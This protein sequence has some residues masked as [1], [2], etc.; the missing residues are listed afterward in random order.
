MARS[1]TSLLPTAGL[2]QSPFGIL[3]PATTTYSHDEDY[4]T[5]GFTYEV[6]DAGVKIANGI[7]YGANQTPAI[8]VIDN[9]DSTE[10]FKTYYPFDIQASI[11]LSTFGTTPDEVKAS[12]T[13][14]L[15]LVTQ[16]AIEIEFWNGD[17]AKTLTSDNDNRYLAGAQTVD[18]TPTPGTAI[19]PRYGQAILEQALAD[20]ALGAQG[21]LHVTRDV[22]SALKVTADGETLRT[23]LGT[24]VVAGIG[25]SR[26]GPDG[27]NAPT[28][29][30]W[31]YATGPV[32]VRLGAVHI[33]PEKVN[34]SVD[35]RINQIEYFVDR[36]AAVTWSTSD[37]FA[38]LI[39]LSLDY[40]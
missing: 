6:E 24:P 2:E 11:R 8:T 21:V 15:D 33:V 31:M 3:S 28:G 38:V 22:A 18:L 7:M 30:A 40:A 34:Q 12:A 35:V 37:S 29:K 19:K 14:A 39:D 26:R 1:N 32:S 9:T 13:K 4:F 16:K 23:N 5:S 17:V 25:Y 36:A 20:A 27:A 10:R